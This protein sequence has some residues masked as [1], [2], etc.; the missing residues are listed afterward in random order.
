MT[1]IN[2]YKYL[3]EKYNIFCLNG[4]EYFCAIL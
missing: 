2:L 4:Y 3:K 1:G